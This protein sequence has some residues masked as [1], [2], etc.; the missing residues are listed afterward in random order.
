MDE[1]V[2]GVENRQEYLQHYA[3][4]FGL[5]YLNELKARSYLSVPADYGASWRRAWDDDDVSFNF[6]MTRDEFLQ[7]L[8][9]KGGFVDG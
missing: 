5:K 1:W 8:E 3:D 4:R 2:Y 6:Q 7:A 9:E